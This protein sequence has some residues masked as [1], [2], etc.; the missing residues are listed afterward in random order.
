M[1]IPSRRAGGGLR[2][3][4]RGVVVALLF[5]S[6]WGA[7][8][9][10]ATIDHVELVTQPIATEAGLR[11]VDVPIV[12]EGSLWDG[13]WAL[14]EMTTRPIPIQTFRGL[15]VRNAAALARL[16]VRVLRNETRTQGAHPGPPGLFGD[17]L[18]V[19]LDVADFHADSAFGYSLS[20]LVPATV[21]CMLSNARRSARVLRYLDLRVAGDRKFASFERVYR[22]SEIPWVPDTRELDE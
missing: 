1:E 13:A 12:S 2:R 15:E 14:V 22:V 11:A 21:T 18:R 20:T 5:T 9:S 8:T 19:V 4:V 17:T 16:R 3:V 6:T 7:K 10:D